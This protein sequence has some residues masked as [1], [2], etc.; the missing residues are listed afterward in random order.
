MALLVNK[1][2][3]DLQF[4]PSTT[5]ALK[6]LLENPN[7]LAQSKPISL[8]VS[9]MSFKAAEMAEEEKRV[10][11]QQESGLTADTDDTNAIPLLDRQSMINYSDVI[12]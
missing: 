8:S 11:E 12:L 4:K 9:S 10:Q 5:P 7:I 6:A 1:E 2:E 3:L